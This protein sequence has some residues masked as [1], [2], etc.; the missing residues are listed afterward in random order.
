MES[1]KT[2][3]PECHRIDFDNLETFRLVTM[4]KP[5]DLLEAHSL[6]MLLVTKPA[7]VRY[8]SGFTSPEDGQVVVSA[9]GMLLLT[10]S[11]YTVQAEQESRIP[12]RI[13]RQE[14]KRMAPA[15]LLK[16]RVGVEA[17]HMNLA[18]LE[19]LKE[20]SAAEYVPTQGLVE[21][22]RQVKSP[23]EIEKIRAAA[24][25]ADRAWS[26]VL[27]YL[28]PGVCEKD[29]AL[30]LESFM[31]RQGAEDAAFEIIVASG[32]RGAMPHGVASSKKLARGELVTLDFGALVE[33][34]HSDMTR[35]VALGKTSK[36][37]KQL[38]HAVLEAQEEALAQVGSGKSGKELDA[39]A[40]GVLQEKGY[41]EYFVH[42][43]GHG[44]GLAVHEGPSLSA[45]SEDVLALGN[46]VTVEPGAYVKGLG[47]VRIEDLVLVTESGQEVLSKSSKSW[48]EL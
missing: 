35:T 1:L 12:L 7:N 3:A 45:L 21:K 15:D 9:E 10:D 42:S 44:V 46:V 29:I 37:L 47:G 48:L 30:E 28:K 5:A 20:R 41:G 38:Y 32:E 40:R 36:K 26:H 16:G 24:A 11:R 17:Q 19:A 43:L 13:F 6:D 27:S 33:G 31:R 2:P 23:D 39:V 34:Y 18:Y 22:F 4:I 14:D 8:L 25:L